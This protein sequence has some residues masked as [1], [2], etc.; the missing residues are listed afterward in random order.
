MTRTDRQ[1]DITARVM[2]AQLSACSSC[3]DANRRPSSGQVLNN[4]KA[5]SDCW[6]TTATWS[7]TVSSNHQVNYIY[8]NTL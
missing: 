2:F 6:S 5:Q 1:T 7:A 4:Q 3:V 8:S